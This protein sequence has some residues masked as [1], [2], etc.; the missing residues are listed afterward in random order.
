[1]QLY[2]EPLNATKKNNNDNKELL[3]VLIEKQ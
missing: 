1:M 3:M 2:L